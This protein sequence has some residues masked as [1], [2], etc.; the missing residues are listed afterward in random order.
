MRFLFDSEVRA[1]LEQVRTRPSSELESEELEFK[2]YRDE[3]AFH[4]AKDVA[5]ELS[6]L[7][8]RN[9]GTLIIG[10]KDDTDVN[11]G[12]WVS[13]LAGIPQV[14]PGTTKERIMGRLKP[15]V[16]LS[17]R[18]ISFDNKNYVV[19][20]IAH[21][22]DTLVSTSAGK[23]YIREGKS[24]RPMEPYEIERAVKALVTFDWSA[25]AIDLDPAEVLDPVCI[26]AAQKDFV[27]RRQLKELPTTSAFLEAIGASRN[28][29]LMK[30]GLLF[31]GKEVHIA[32]SLGDYE[33]RFSWKNSTGQLKVN[34]VWAGNLWNAVARAKGHFRE[35]NKTQN[36]KYKDKNFVAPLLDET[37]F[38][39][40]YLNALV[41][42]DYSA[43]GMTSI[44]FT[45]EKM[46]ITSPGQFYGGVTAENIAIHEPR[47][48]NKALARILMTHHLVDRAGMGVLRMGIGSLRYG[49]SFPHFREAQDSIEVSMEAQFIKTPIAVLALDNMDKYGIPELLILNRVHG[50]GSAPVKDLENQLGRL[51]DSPWRAIQQAVTT[52]RSVELCGTPSGLFVRVRPTWKDYLEVGR[53]FRPSAN[54]AKQLGL[55]SYLKQHGDASNSDLRGVL[56][57]THSSQTSRFLKDAKYVHRTGSGPSARWSL[58]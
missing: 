43:E 10:V 28:G 37:A 9:G 51:V 6:A 55:Y 38:H 56:N 58:L 45:G 39:E 41:H 11:A 22:R 46:V 5:D 48:R 13:Q 7:A 20:A 1:I 31:L 4:N 19:V 26:Q 29:I 17:V 50:V 16:E 21:P 49:R 53:L 8:N 47:H 3:Q 12:N 44:N 40:A 18:N 35:C 33:Y 27:E 15:K 14:D 32:R 36:Y 54:S 25:D 34:D 57:H 24:S 52:L 42:R 2:G 23:T 30:G